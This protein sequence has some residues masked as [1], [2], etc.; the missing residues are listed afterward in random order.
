MHISTLTKSL[1]FTVVLILIASCVF[2]GLSPVRETNAMYC[3]LFHRKSN[4]T[5]KVRWHVFRVK[6]SLYWRICEMYRKFCHRLHCII[7]VGQRYS[8]ICYLSFSRLS[9]ILA[10]YERAFARMHYLSPTNHSWTTTCSTTTVVSSNPFYLSSC[11]HPVPMQSNYSML[12]A[13]IGKRR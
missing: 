11:Q 13:P 7:R 6:I 3:I 2:N 9:W 5:N 1:I 12:D 8:G 10:T 4:Y